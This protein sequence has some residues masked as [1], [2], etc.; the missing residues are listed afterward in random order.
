ML[1]MVSISLPTAAPPSGGDPSK[2]CHDPETP[3]NL[4]KLV[5]RVWRHK[6]GLV[7]GF[8]KKYKVKR[9]VWYKAHEDIKAAITREKQ[10]KNWI[11]ACAGMT[12]PCHRGLTEYHGKRSRTASLGW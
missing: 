9:L 3:R 8:T 7:S 2:F 5:K 1:R 4:L 10:I 11:P 6:A 12:V